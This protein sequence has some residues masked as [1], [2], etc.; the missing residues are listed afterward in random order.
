MPRGDGTGPM[1]MGPMTGRAAGYCAGYAAPGFVNPGGRGLGMARGRGGGFGMGMAWRRGRGGGFARGR[2]VTPLSPA[3]YAAAPSREDELDMLRS[4]AD[5]LKEQIDA[6][7]Q[8][9]G[10]LDQQK[11]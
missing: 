4:Q 1:G 8:R 3:A 2:F 10:E 5:W 6:I 11:S 9:I 7:N